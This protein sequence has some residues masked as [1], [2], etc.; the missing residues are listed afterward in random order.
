[1]HLTRRWM[2]LEG[3]AIVPGILFLAGIAAI[4]IS[5]GNMTFLVVGDAAVFLSGIAFMK[6]LK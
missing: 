6:V 2:N 4:F 1:M 5:G 3:A